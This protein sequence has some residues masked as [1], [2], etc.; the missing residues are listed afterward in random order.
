[1]D[2]SPPESQTVRFVQASKIKV[3]TIPGLTKMICIAFQKPTQQKVFSKGISKSTL[4]EQTQTP[5][6]KKKNK[7]GCSNPLSTCKEGLYMTK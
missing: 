7:V 5:G 2:G 1:M 4:A 3:K 6:K